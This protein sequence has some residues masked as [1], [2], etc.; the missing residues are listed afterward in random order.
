MLRSEQLKSYVNCTEKNL[1]NLMS[2]GTKENSTQK[3]EIQVLEK[4]GNEVWNLAK[5]SMLVIG[6]TVNRKF[7]IS[8]L[9]STLKLVF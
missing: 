1:Y 3:M 9:I 7:Q 6:L 8:R 4:K 2:W 5:I